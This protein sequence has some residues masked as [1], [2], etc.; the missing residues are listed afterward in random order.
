MNFIDNLATRWTNFIRSN[1]Q[2]AASEKVLFYAISL[3]INTFLSYFCT[4]LICAFTNHLQQAVIVIV[5][6]SL[7]RTTS[8][9]VHLSTSLRCCTYS[10]LMFTIISHISFDFNYMHIGL[11]IT[12]LSS[13]ILMRTAP[14]GIKNIS[15][16]PEKHYPL[17]KLISV[18][19]VLSNIYIGSSIIAIA[20]FVQAIHTTKFGYSLISFVE[21]IID[22]TLGKEGAEHES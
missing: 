16:I 18:A 9:G 3:S 14:E 20:F 11:I 10:I 19:L 21:R 8:G 4:L 13:L 17:L 12:I 15:R 2:N 5:M 7:L 1:Y 6:Y 22:H